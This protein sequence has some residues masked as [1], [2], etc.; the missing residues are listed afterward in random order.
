MW[1][2]MPHLHACGHVVQACH[3]SVELVQN[4]AAC[5]VAIACNQGTA[6]PNQQNVAAAPHLLS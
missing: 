3:C 2:S 5:A 6:M 1:A 4:L